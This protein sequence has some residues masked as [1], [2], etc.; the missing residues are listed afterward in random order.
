MFRPNRSHVQVQ[1]LTPV[2]SLSEK[3]ASRLDENWAGVFYRQYFSR[4]DEQP[5]AVLY[6]DKD[7]RPNTPVN[8]LGE[9]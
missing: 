3:L 7:S 4:I 8:V 2:D 6:S 9:C 5:F 1:M